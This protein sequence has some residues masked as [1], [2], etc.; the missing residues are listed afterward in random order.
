MLRQIYEAVRGKVEM[1][2]GDIRG[3]CYALKPIPP[4]N[5]YKN[6]KKP[7]VR[8]ENSSTLAELCKD[9]TT[10]IRGGEGYFLPAD[11]FRSL[12]I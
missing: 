2:M 9:A 6:S 1:I 11:P 3:F 4:R 12:L 7:E 10:A 8:E 5:L